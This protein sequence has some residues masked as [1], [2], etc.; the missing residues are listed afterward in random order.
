MM[1]DTVG[2]LHR[3]LRASLEPHLE[4][5]LIRHKEAAAKADWSCHEFLPLDAFR[6][7][8]C[9]HRPLSRAAYAAVEMALLTEV[10]LPWYTAG[11]YHGLQ[12]CPAPI[13]EFVRVWTSEEDQHAT[14]LETY[15]LL[16]DNGDPAAR[17]RARKAV[18]A[19][20][21]THQLGGPF[22][23]MVYTAIQE[24]VTRTFYLCTA[25]ACDQEAPGLAA[26]LRRIAKDETLHMAFYRDV[27]KVHL[28][29]DSGYLQPLAAVM[30]RFQMPWSASCAGDFAERQ[31]YVAAHGVFTLADYY[32]DVVQFLWSYWAIDRLAPPRGEARRALAQLR[33][34]RA[35]LRKAAGCRVAGLAA[36]GEPE[37]AAETVPSSLASRAD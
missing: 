11:L 22:E 9:R 5:L 25:R 33:R 21:W 3:D 2:G 10:N 26:A 29:L 18:I 4:A 19:A 24:A 34:Y 7:D 8:P 31:A 16:S 15:L 12:G 35:A 17:A 14:L 13:Q 37:G 23:G 20:G 28:E 36:E 6:A 30:C 1:T 32:H 27:V